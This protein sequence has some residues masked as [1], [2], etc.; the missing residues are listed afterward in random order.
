MSKF[1][2]RASDAEEKAGEYVTALLDVLDDRDPLTVQSKQPAA[3]REAVKGL[4]ESQLRT[5]E[6]PGKWAVLDVLGHLADTELVYR[7]RMRQIVAEPG[8]E[9]PGYDQDAWADGLRYTDAEVEDVLREF[10]ALRSAHLRWIRQL[11]DEELDREGVHGGRGPE[12]VRH[13]VRLIA[14]HDL[15]HRRQIQRIRASGV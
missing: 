2:Y 8:S 7:Y 15:V 4:D 9:L 13:M 1:T 11:S 10:E 6:A 14:A 12:S 5:P 3:L